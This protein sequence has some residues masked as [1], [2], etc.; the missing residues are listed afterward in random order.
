MT[1]ILGFIPYS[2]R[3]LTSL[4]HL[5]LSNNFI[6]GKIIR[7]TIIIFIIMTLI[8]LFLFI[9]FDDINEVTSLTHLDISN[10][11]IIGTLIRDYNNL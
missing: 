11:K 1:L 9:G 3:K 10:N 7:D 6:T 8:C 2:I 5:D 4:E